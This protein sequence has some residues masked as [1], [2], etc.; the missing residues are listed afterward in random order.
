V[1]SIR[2]GLIDGLEGAHRRFHTAAQELTGRDAREMLGKSV[3]LVI[4]KPSG[5]GFFA[6]TCC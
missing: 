2:S 3:D 1:S 6:K 4:E 5:P